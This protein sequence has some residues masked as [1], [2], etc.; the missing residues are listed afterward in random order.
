M[1]SGITGTPLL[2]P[3]PTAYTASS[4]SMLTPGIQQIWSKEIL[5]Q[6][7]PI[8]RFEQFMVDLAA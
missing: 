5:F 7:M 2:S 4:S 1:A 8:L 6:A 3:T